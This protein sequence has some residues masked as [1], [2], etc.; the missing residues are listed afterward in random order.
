LIT[1]DTWKIGITSGLKTAFVLLKIIIPVFAFVTFLEHTPI[2]EWISDVMD[3]LLHLVGLP[4]KASMAIVTGMF[5]NFY[6][7]IGI[8]V[9]LELTAWQMT[10]IAVMLS[11]CH[12]L[13]IETAIINKAGIRGWPIAG[14]RFVTAIIAGVLLNGLGRIWL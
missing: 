10:I 6:A 13:I 12:E 3:P 2:V 14:I 8:I 5:F 1:T 11:C 7:S 9:A 4:G